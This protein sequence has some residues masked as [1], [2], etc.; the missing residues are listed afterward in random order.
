MP[1]INDVGGVEGFGPVLEEPDEPPFHADWEAHVFAMNRALVGRGV[2]NLDEFRDAV[3][4]TMS[5]ES[6]YYENWF[7]AIQTLL[8]EKGHV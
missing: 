3:E 6:S 2:Y 1:R 5:H 4:R 7:R 8:K